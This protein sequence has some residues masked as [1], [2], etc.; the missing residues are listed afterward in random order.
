MKKENTKERV[1]I[2]SRVEE[3]LRGAPIEKLRTIYNLIAAFLL[4]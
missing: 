1:Y 3:L 2:L 4:D